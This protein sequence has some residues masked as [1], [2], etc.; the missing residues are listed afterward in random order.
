MTLP[1]T[2]FISHGAPTLLIDPELPGKALRKLGQRLP[3]PKA[4]LMMSAH[5]NTG[6]P[7]VSNA[8]Q[9]ETIYDF[10]GFPAEL[11]AM[12]YPAPGAP[13]VADQVAYKLSSAGINVSQQ[14]YGLDHGAWVPLCLLF[15]KA[16]IP[17]LQ[18]SV[19]SRLG[20]DHHWRVGVALQSLREDGVM[21]IGSG[22]FTH[23]LREIDLNARLGRSSAWAQEFV[24]WMQ[25][26]IAIAHQADLLNYRHKA[27]H[28]ERAHPTDEHLLP[29]FTA[30]GAAGTSPQV[31]HLAFGFSFNTM[32]WDSYLF[33]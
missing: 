31:E 1:P 30:M 19:Q 24:D 15:P 13:M 29:L 7:T 32:S 26:R 17:V 25:Q 6:T 3:R 11:Y 9:P 33:W 12:R 14:P 2:L 8:E 22:Q 4:I 5:W 27:P 23:N 18:L 21:I 16:D 20:A 10:Y 28:A